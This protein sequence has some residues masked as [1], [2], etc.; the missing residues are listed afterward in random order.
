[1]RMSDIRPKI[2]VVNDDPFD[3]Q[4]YRDILS[5]FDAD[6]LEAADGA[7]ALEAAREH[8]LAVI[9]LD[10]GLRGMSGHEV[11]SLLRLH[12]DREYVPVI[13]VAPPGVP[14]DELR[15]GYRVGAVDC[16]NNSPNESE[17]LRQKVQVFLHIHRRRTELRRAVEQLDERNRQLQTEHAHARQMAT[18][19]P[20][21][22]LPNRALFNDRLD[23][24]LNRGV[25][26]G[27]RFALAYLDLD[28]FKGI[29]DR[30]GHAAGD[31]LIVAVARRLVDTVRRNDT[32]A[33]L[34]GDEFALL[35]EGLDAQTAGGYLGDKILRA[36]TVPCTLQ[37]TLAGA[38]VEVQ[39][40]ASIGLALYPAHGDCREQLLIHA[41]A[42]MYEAKRA[43]GG[44]REFRADAP[45]GVHL[46][47]GTGRPRPSAPRAG[48]EQEETFANSRN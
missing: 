4:T 17:I 34:G 24:A 33:R 27:T 38:P 30:F 13:F 26:Y 5:A 22:G 7:A 47:G 40:A 21:T 37:A 31:E 1:M 10:L 8:D 9:L 6:V 41:D 28:R 43:G 35:F 32:V 46:V 15:Q 12:Q 45:P 20:L 25:R 16:V 2:L 29:N 48:K 23:S 19:D 11:A 3:Q 42:A 36:V 14:A 18:H 44:M 39:P